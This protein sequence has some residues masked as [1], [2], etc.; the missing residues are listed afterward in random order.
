MHGHMNVK[1]KSFVSNL[2]NIHMACAASLLMF[3]AIQF[4]FGVWSVLSSSKKRSQ[5][6]KYCSGTK[7]QFLNS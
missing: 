1:D 7:L 6:S 2:A 3:M 5:A 4:W